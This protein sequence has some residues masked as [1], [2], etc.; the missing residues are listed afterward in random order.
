M[1]SRPFMTLAGAGLAME[2]LGT[3]LG[4]RGLLEFGYMLLIVSLVLSLVFREPP[5]LRQ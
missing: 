3:L 1:K 4:L 5:L 2:V